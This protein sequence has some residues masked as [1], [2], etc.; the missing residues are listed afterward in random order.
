[1]TKCVTV[2]SHLIDIEDSHAVSTDLVKIIV[3][4]CKNAYFSVNLYSAFV[5]SFT[6][7]FRRKVSVKV[8]VM[9]LELKPTTSTC[10]SMR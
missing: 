4:R 10:G 6:E 9:E 2:F 7:T 5:T 1:M 8:G 3:S